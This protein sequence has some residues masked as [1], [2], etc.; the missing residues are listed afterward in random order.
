MKYHT[1][2]PTLQIEKCFSTI[3]LITLKGWVHSLIGCVRTV[4]SSPSS[5]CFFACTISLDGY[6]F[7]FLWKSSPQ[8]LEGRA[9]TIL[10][11]CSSH[12]LASTWR[13]QFLRGGIV[14]SFWRKG[15][16]SSLRSWEHCAATSWDSFVAQLF[17]LAAGFVWYAPLASELSHVFS[18]TRPLTQ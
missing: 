15:F 3:Q 11:S 14:A 9:I 7:R 10:V 18:T 6:K 2:T 4:C 17:E 8:E 12:S 13:H 16:S 1:P 5:A